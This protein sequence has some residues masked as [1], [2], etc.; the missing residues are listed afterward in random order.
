MKFSS[1]AVAC[2]DVRPALERLC[3]S[4]ASE[5]GSV[6]PDLA[7]CFFTS[8][9]EDEGEVLAA[10][11]NRRF[12]S[13]TVIGCSA[14]G[15]VGPE[16]E[17]ERTPAI[18]LLLAS[19]PEVRIRPFA[20]TGQELAEADAETLARRLDTQPDELPAFLFFGDPFSMPIYVLLDRFNQAYPGR[21]LLGGMASG[22]EAP[23]QSVLL[24]GDQALRSG[25]VGVALSGP[26]QISAVVSQGCRPIG[27]PLVIT[28][29]KRNVLNELGG[30]PAIARLREVIESL[31]PDEAQLV[32]RSGAVFLGRVINEY[33]ETFKRGDF[34][35][36]NLIGFDSASGA[37]AVAEELRVGATVQFHLRDA[38]SADEDMRQ[39]LAPHANEIRPAGA[40][41]FSCNGRGTRMWAQPNHDVSTLQK[42]CGPVPTAGFF[43]AGEF[44]PVG[45]RN[46]IHGHTASIA[47]FRAAT[48]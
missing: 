45:G 38:E 10:E 11:L 21:P 32:N 5:L 3:E 24:M 1:A 25:G 48:R 39:L 34:L 15:V 19:L 13:A 8:H 42:L 37:I 4:A 20:L 23:G 9:F 36:R 17:L 35:I 41:L 22:C 44:G 28:K 40:L 6:S 16:S 18:S 2:P 33:Q 7:V 27:Q 30:R 29:C 43:A 26:I 14:E 46:F 31:P 12:S 47:L